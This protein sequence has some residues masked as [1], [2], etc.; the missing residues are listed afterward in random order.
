MDTCLQNLVYEKQEVNGSFDWLHIKTTNHV[1]ECSGDPTK[2]AAILIIFLDEIVPN[3]A[4]PDFEYE[5]YVPLVGGQ[6]KVWR[7]VKAR[8]LT[9]DKLQITQV[10]ELKYSDIRTLVLEDL[11]FAKEDIFKYRTVFTIGD[12][13]G[14][15]LK[16]TFNGVTLTSKI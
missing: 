2:L 5:L 13:V 1:I 3:F 9:E 7:P 16:G 8:M 10:P 4:D 11:T 15:E 14:V 6:T 12:I